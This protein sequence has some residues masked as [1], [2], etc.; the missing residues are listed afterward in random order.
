VWAE[1]VGSDPRGR[2][3][4][5]G[6]LLHRE[7]GLEVDLGGFYAFVPEPQGDY[8][9]VDTGLEQ[10]HGSGVAENVGRDMLSGECGTAAS[11]GLCVLGDE[12]LDGVAAE[13]GALPSGEDEIG[14]GGSSL[15]E[16]SADQV[17]GLSSQRGA[18]L[19]TALT[20]TAKVRT[21]AEDDVFDA[22]GG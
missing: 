16:P 7:V 4:R 18:A 15:S 6:S 3:S 5:Q 19:L 8:G 14:G 17:G 20:S 9:A 21:G 2:G 11:G 10:A 22:Q 12:V 1:A 13:G